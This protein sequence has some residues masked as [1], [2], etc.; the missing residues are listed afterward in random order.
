MIV[1]KRYNNYISRVGNAVFSLAKRGFFVILMLIA[2]NICLGLFLF[3]K[4]VI[5]S[6][7]QGYDDNL[8]LQFKEIIYQSVIQKRQNITDFISN[9]SP[10]EYK[11]PFLRIPP[12]KSQQ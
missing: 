7:T 12:Q 11:D 1:S 2:F 3:Y 5:F 10:Q 8:S 9:Y 6:H 4:Y